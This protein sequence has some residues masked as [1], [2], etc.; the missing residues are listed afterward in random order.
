MVADRLPVTT[1]VLRGHR[2]SLVLW[3]SSLAAVSVIYISYYPAIGA[4][5]MAAMIDSLPRQMVDAL[6][7]DAIG[8]AP[9][10][11]TSTIY[12]LLGPILLLVHG[13]ALGA[14]WIAGQEEDGTLELE[15]TAPVSRRQVYAGRLIALLVDLTA[16]I[17]TLTTVV[18]LLTLLLD[19]DV[20]VTGVLAGGVGLLLLVLAFAVTAFAIGAATGR[21]ALALGVAAGLAVI[22]YMLQALGPVVGADWMTTVSPFAWFVDTNPL[23]DGFH[24]HWW[25]L[26]GVAVVAG[27]AGLW[28]FERRDLMA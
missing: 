16:L 25:R 23:V 14:R 18:L 15:L 13:L 24:P 26:V 22:A 10:Y 28:G 4:D 5:E 19:L 8:T 3:A 1:G 21:R 17:A 11:L 27:F 2:R 9:G 12:G 20:D 7:Y 6:G